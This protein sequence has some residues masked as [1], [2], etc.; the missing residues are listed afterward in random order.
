MTIALQE[1]FPMSG[2]IKIDLVYADKLV[3]YY[4]EDNLIVLVPRQ[5]LLSMLYLTNRTSDPITSLQ[6]GTGGA[7]DPA[8]AFPRPVSKGLSSLFNSTITLPTTYTVDNTAPSVTFI[9]DVAENQ[10]NG[11][12]I[13]EAALFTAAGTMFNIKTFPGIP[14][15]SQFSIHIQ[16]TIDFS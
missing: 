1:R 16:W 3:P 14:K 12:L 9:A 11:T 2:R 15:T 5:N 13:D 8:G 10:G 7:I 4:E 6:V